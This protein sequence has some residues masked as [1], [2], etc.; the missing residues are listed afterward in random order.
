MTAISIG[1]SWV[2]L[3]FKESLVHLFIVIL[4]EVVVISSF[5]CYEFSIG[6]GI[7]AVPEPLTLT[8]SGTIDPFLAES[9]ESSC[10]FS[11]VHNVVVV[12]VVYR[13]VK[14]CCFLHG[15]VWVLG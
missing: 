1:A 15:G 5:E 4:R 9:F 10:E 7:V 6:L 11:N 14:L 13:E 3:T 2:D 8:F 12:V